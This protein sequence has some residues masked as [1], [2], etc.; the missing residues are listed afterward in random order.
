MSDNNSDS[1]KGGGG[2]EKR[3]QQEEQ[4]VVNNNVKKYEYLDHTADV[5]FHSWGD[6]L[7]EAFIQIIYAMFDY[8]T[9]L[10]TVEVDANDPQ[11]IEFEVEG[12]DL[13]TL[14]YNFM[15]EFL[16]VF[17]TDFFVPKRVWFIDFMGGGDEGV[18]S[19]KVRAEGETFDLQKHPQGT[20]IKAITYSNMQIYNSDDK[21]EIYVI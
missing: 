11:M 17:S 16:F 1:P 2:D 19:V 12:H 4:L 14:L 3:E 10:E 18:F 9:D 5:Q 6:S 20:E 7:E 15:D 13:D 21:H 8:I